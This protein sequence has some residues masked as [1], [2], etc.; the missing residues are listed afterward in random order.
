M[1]ARKQRSRFARAVPAFAAIVVV[2]FTF[3]VRLVG[4]QIVDAAAL[5]EEAI[6]RRGVEST[7]WESRGQ[8][9]DRN[10]A[11][12][13]SGV[14]R[15]D[16][17]LAPVNMKDFKRP[18]S[19]TDKAE[20]VTVDEALKKIANI[21]GQDPGKLRASVDAMLAADPESEFGYLAQMV[22]L[23]EYQKVREL[24][25]PWVY[26]ERHPMRTYPNG[27]VG[28]SLIGFVGSDGEPLAGVESQYNACLAGV[29][30]EEAYERSADGVTIPGSVVV[31]K[32][33]VAG[34]DLKLTID[35]DTQWRAQQILAEEAKRVNAEYGTITVVEAKTGELVAAAEYPTVDPNDPTTT[36]AEFRGANT[37]T[38][39]YEP[40]SI[41]KPVTAA[42]LYDKGAISPNDVITVPDHWPKDDGAS[43][44]DDAPHDP[45][46]MNMNGVLTES[47]NVG[48][49]EFASRIPKQERYEAMLKFGFTTRT[50]VNFP[51]EEPGVMRDASEWDIQT[52]HASTFGHGLT[53][54]P[55]QMASAFQ[56]IANKG[57]QKPLQL[58]R[59]CTKP[60]GT[61]TDVPDTTGTPV[62]SEKA[63]KLTLEGMEA[64]A[65][66]GWLADQVAVP[67]YRIGIKTGTSERVDPE[68]GT[69]LKGEHNISLVGVAPI[70]DP[71]YVVLVTLSHPTNI[72][73]S[74]AA[75]PAWQKTMSYVLSVNGVAPSAQPW[76]DI[77]IVK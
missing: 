36:D 5:N 71:Q 52:E 68:T 41:M 69:Y 24:H 51:G 25:I 10:G 2:V 22:T 34:G 12:L 60:D 55:A 64:T 43:F 35:A 1:A 38:A 23:E 26:F 7:L 13:A 17:T 61:V 67:G 18:N 50:A 73:N 72:R 29:N 4:L 21:T 42:I 16:I 3:L 48:T 44:G 75:A 32:E 33:P 14:D 15:F 54:T 49:A 59:G 6:G 74:S 58:V 40:G 63:A 65:R 45:V 30:G 62:V 53:T 9:V 66:E 46:Q 39:P 19:E 77:N 47:S 28:G 31:I 8:I 57:E 70:D 11:V 76:P 37:F 20:I 27:A 56:T